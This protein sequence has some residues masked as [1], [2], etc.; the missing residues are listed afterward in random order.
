VNEAIVPVTLTGLA[1]VF[2]HVGETITVSPGSNTPFPEA[3]TVRLLERSGAATVVKLRGPALQLPLE[4][5][6]AALARQ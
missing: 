3:F 5:L 2:C 6:F 1:V 4:Q